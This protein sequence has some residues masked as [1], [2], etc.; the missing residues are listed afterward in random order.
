M[1]ES[2]FGKLM[3]RIRLLTYNIA[4]A[5]GL[6]LHQT[7]RPRSKIRAQLLNIAHLINRLDADIVA[8]QE[9]DENSRWTGSFDHLAY[10][11]D[12]TGLPHAVHGVNNR[13]ESPLFHFSYGNAVLSRFPITHYENVPFGRGLIGEKGVLFTEVATPAGRLP[14]VN[15]HMHHRSRASRLKQAARMMEFLGEQR[16]HRAAHWVAGPIICGDLNNPAHAPDATAMLLGYL[17]Q[18][19]N[20]MLVPKGATGLPLRTFPS[21]WPQRALDYVYLPSKCTRVEV[22]VVRSYLSDH[23]PGLVEFHL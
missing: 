3:R 23:R 2:G 14:V 18:F 1:G 16:T 15:V 22:T 9:I 13:R 11:R 17:E 7:L 8:L 10:L 19:D 12:H 21:V 20:Y 4:H 5:R 6:G